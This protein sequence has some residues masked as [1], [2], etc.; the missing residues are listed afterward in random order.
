M[1]VKDFGTYK[2]ISF[3]SPDRIESVQQR[4]LREHITYCKKYSPFYQRIF[5]KHNINPQ[6]ISLDNLCDIP[7]TDKVDIENDNDAFLAVSPER[8]AD[9]VFS[10]GTTG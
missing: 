5:K 8:I 3:T 2:E 10:S 1:R 4:L 9:I 6:K 7:F